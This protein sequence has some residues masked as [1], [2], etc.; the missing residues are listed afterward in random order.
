[1]INYIIIAIALSI[2][3]AV[4]NGL[5]IN[6]KQQPNVILAARISNTWHIISFM[7]RFGLFIQLALLLNI[8]GIILGV[9]LLWPGYNIIIHMIIGQK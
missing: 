1:M 6:W 9:L 5:V 3:F 8:W 4:F 2:L 7:I